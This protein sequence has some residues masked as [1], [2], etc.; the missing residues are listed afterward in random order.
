MYLE[1]ISKIFPGNV[2]AAKH[3]QRNGNTPKPF[4]TSGVAAGASTCDTLP[5]AEGREYGKA[6]EE[7]WG[8]GAMSALREPLPLPP[9]PFGTKKAAA[10]SAA[11]AQAAGGTGGEAGGEGVGRVGASEGE[12]VLLLACLCRGLGTT[13]VV[14]VPEILGR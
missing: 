3:Q 9:P 12:V 7:D 2:P 6:L 4:K 14:R 10:A 13:F 8:N 11:G 1:Q 5:S